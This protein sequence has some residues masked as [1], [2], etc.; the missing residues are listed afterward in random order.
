MSECQ[1][2]RNRRI[3]KIRARVEH[4]F[5]QIAQMGGKCLR[6]IGQARATACMTLMAACYNLK[7]LAMFL[8]TGVDAF[9][10]E[11]L[12]TPTPRTDCLHPSDARHAPAPKCP[13]V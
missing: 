12:K 7:R 3:G 2:G 11:P 4:P 1:K 6:T 8:Q 10:R 9:Y 13:E 5:A